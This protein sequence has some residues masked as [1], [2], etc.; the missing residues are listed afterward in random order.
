VELISS[1]NDKVLHPERIENA[2]KMLPAINNVIVVG[3]H[4]PYLT[5]VIS[6]DPYFMVR[7][8]AI[9]HVHMSMADLNY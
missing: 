7:G 5:A 4:K 8:C 9:R 6:L 1:L 2:L 3:H